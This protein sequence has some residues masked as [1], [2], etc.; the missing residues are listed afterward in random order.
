[1]LHHLL[2]AIAKVL[3]AP[4]IFVLGLAGYN[5]Q[6]PVQSQPQSFGSVTPVGASNFTLAGAGINST[7]TTIPLASFTTPD[8][9]PITMSMLGT[10]GY[11]ALEPQTVAKLEDIT[12]S[13]VV[14]NA[15]GSATLT[16]VT[17]GNDFVTPY[18]PSVS[19]AHSH[20]GGAT[21][22][23]T[24]TAGF[25]TQFAS[26]NNAQSIS[27]VWTFSHLTPPQYDTVYNASGHQFVSFDQL[28]A[29]TIL[30]AATSTENALGLVQLN[31]SV[32]VG[33]GTASSS[34]GAPFVIEN[35][36]ATTTPGTLCTGGT[37]NCI[38]AAING[39]LSQAWLDL[40]AAFTVTGNWVFQGTVNILANTSK[41]LTLNG[42]TYT[43]GSSRAAS[44][45]V[46]MEDG[47]GNLT[48]ETNTPPRYTF[49]TTTLSTTLTNGYA[50]TSPA[51][52]VPA[53]TLNASST[54][55]VNINGTY[56]R[57]GANPGAVLLRTS[58][59]TTIATC[60]LPLPS[61]N[62]D[63]QR[64][65]VNI[66]VVFNNTTSA[67]TYICNGVAV[68][69]TTIAA[70]NAMSASGT[71][72][73]NLSGSVGYVAVLDATNSSIAGNLS[74]ASIIVSP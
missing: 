30:G 55:A 21:F 39:K 60:T 11:G 50:S 70:T 51:L 25:Y 73:V 22:I 74:N 4:T 71:S 56:T 61:A 3:V 37:W 14:Q 8:G 36:F 65:S 6:A 72:A 46:L 27:G 32:N 16:G 5:F 31:S 17:R 49:A 33:L 13:G 20:A 47:A 40:T 34:A 1:M 48:F 64:F 57:N 52:N 19:L 41:P 26:V 18:A 23:L 15:N 68:D 35:K 7:Q 58:A 59:G 53:N 38:P 62:S 69:T 63:I 43:F 9:R 12:F 2:I 24:N 66:Q 67:E 45:T 44:S 10:I 28:N 54:I 42:L 29:V